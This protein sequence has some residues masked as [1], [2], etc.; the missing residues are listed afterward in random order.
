MY[1]IYIH[2]YTCVYIYIYICVCIHTYTHP[3][4]KS[5][6]APPPAAPGPARR[7]AE[8]PSA[9]GLSTHPFGPKTRRGVADGQMGRW[10]DGRSGGS[11]KIMIMEAII[12]LTIM[13]LT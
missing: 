12:T 7:P 2:T 9:Q 10:A 1:Y 3:E 8:H 13:I 6:R 5:C 11:E 4:G